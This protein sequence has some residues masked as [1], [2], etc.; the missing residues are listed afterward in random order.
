MAITDFESF[1]PTMLM[2]GL[3]SSATGS[4]F[5]NKDIRGMRREM[6]GE[7]DRIADAQERRGETLDPENPDDRARILST[8]A[9]QI[10][11]GREAELKVRDRRPDLFAKPSS[12]LQ[13]ERPDIMDDERRRRRM[14]M[15]A[16]GV[17]QGI[18]Y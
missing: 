13:P 17:A 7:A 3:A 10:Q 8:R 4:G 14:A 5:R 6:L 12:A 11:L 15:A 2:R 18:D 16:A 9:D 1:R